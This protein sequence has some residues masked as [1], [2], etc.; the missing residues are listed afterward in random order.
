MPDKVTI[1]LLAPEMVAVIPPGRV[2]AAIT[3]PTCQLVSVTVAPVRF[4]KLT[5][6]M[7]ISVSA[8]ETPTAFSV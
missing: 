1:L 8:T 2:P 5:L 7:A 3:S 6:V 4:G